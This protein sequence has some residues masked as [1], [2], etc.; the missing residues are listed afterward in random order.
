MFRLKATTCL[1]VDIMHAWKDIWTKMQ[2]LLNQYKMVTSMTVRRV[3]EQTWEMSLCLLIAVHFFHPK[4]RWQIWPL[5]RVAYG[6]W[7]ISHRAKE[8]ERLAGGGA[9]L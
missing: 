2:S 6:L 8:A 1:L 7:G 4:V 9:E 5:T 3:R